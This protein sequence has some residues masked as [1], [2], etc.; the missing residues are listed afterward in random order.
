MGQYDLP[1][2]LDYVATYTGI[3]KIAYIGH[4]QGTAQM[5]YGLAENQDYFESR[6]SV[7]VALGSVTLLEHATA[8]YLTYTADNYEKVD[9]YLALYNVHEIMADKNWWWNIEYHIWCNENQ[10]DCFLKG[11]ESVT[12]NPD[13]DDEDRYMVYGAHNPSGASVRSLLFFAQNIKMNRFQK[14][15]PKFNQ[16][17]PLKNER[18]TELIPLQNITKVPVAIFIGGDDIVAN[19][20]DG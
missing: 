2:E 7:F 19:P 4:S 16:P 13:W 12:S 8:G 11:E 10:D 18:T 17:N 6:I 3:E 15:A 14:W 5:Y 1:A 9:N 20:T